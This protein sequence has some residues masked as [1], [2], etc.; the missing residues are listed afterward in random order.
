M[1]KIIKRIIFLLL[2]LMVSEDVLQEV[3]VNGGE[4]RKELFLLYYGCSIFLVQ[5][6]AT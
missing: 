3:P 6:P 1:S 2:I 4:E 5:I